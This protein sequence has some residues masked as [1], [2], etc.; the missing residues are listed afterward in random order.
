MI[1]DNSTAPCRGTKRAIYFC[2]EISAR[3]SK[4]IIF[5]NQ[6]C[7]KKYLKTLLWLGF[8]KKMLFSMLFD[9]NIGANHIF[10]KWLF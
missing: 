8:V 9:V 1:S 5:Q 4:L 3:C 10:I 2:S 6:K 7:L